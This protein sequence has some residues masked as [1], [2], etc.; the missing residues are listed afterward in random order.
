MCGIAGLISPNG[1]PQIVDRMVTAMRHRGPDDQGVEAVGGSAVQVILGNRRLA[2]I[3]LSAAGHMPMYDP[4]TGNWI[5]YNGE[6]Y[7][8]AQVRA[9]LMALGDTFQSGTDTEVILRAY[10]RWGHACVDRLQGMFA[11]AVW[12]L[13]AQ[14]LYLVRDRM[15]KK[16]V[17]YC[18]SSGQ[19]VFA[20][21]VRTLLASGLIARR[22]NP[23]AL[24]SYLFNGFVISPQTIIEGI[25][26]LLPGHW[27]RVS[28]AGKILET[29]AYWHLPAEAA[30]QTR[31]EAM[32]EIRQRLEEA[33]Q[34]RLVSDVPLGA[35]LSGG[36]DSSVIV[37]LMARAGGDV[38]TFSVT[39]D[40]GEF[41]ESPYSNWVAK[42][43]QTRHTEVR[44]R[45]A[46]FEAWLP[47]AL[48]AIDQPTF[49]GLNTY[50]VSRAARESGL[51]V[52]L[53]GAG[54]DELFGGYDFFKQVPTLASLARLGQFVPAPLA[55]IL[56][57]QQSARGT[58]VAGP[59]KTLEL[60]RGL[61]GQSRWDT[62]IAAYQTA[63]MH[64]PSWMRATLLSKALEA[65]KRVWYGLPED[66]RAFLGEGNPQDSGLGQVSRLA[67]LLFLGERCLR[68]ID[69]MSMSVSLEV[70][71]PF[72]DHKLIE[73]VYRVPPAVR[74][75][76]APDKPFEWQ[77]VQPYL[78][79]DYPY[80]KKQGFIFPFQRWLNSA[81]FQG[82]FQALLNEADLVEGVGLN[83]IGLQTL[84]QVFQQDSRRMPW[85]RIWS[86]YVLLHWCRENQVCL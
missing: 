26:S 32:A 17:Y 4:Q 60:L 20:S 19:F 13:A 5:T 11:F 1:S 79:A 77:L 12:D 36:L 82:Q 21:E 73:S 65:D 76:G 67:A 53:T 86:L 83:S 66:Y 22:L 59:L 43:F 44:L 70:R 40:E 80:R 57:D 52:A 69:A 24:E 25:Y 51:T 81:N 61:K 56:Q 31:I 2:I 14:E 16:P 37:A 68:D 84:F 18:Q 29:Q 46:E 8:F 38:R 39:F 75:A 33:V 71:A 47:Q 6:V 55:E 27:M 10:A 7:N 85:S 34:M 48:Q 35:F 63:Q 74:C 30:G 45:P 50:Y 54:G 15:G 72:T 49:D 42:Q 3:D 28:V 78:G 64:F 58:G 9:E 23:T 62:W 41:D